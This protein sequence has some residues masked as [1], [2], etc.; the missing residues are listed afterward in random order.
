MWRGF[1]E[2]PF[3]MRVAEARVSEPGLEELL[4]VP[5]YFELLGR[6]MP[7]AGAAALDVL[8]AEHLLVR[9]GQCWDITNLGA[10]LIARDVGAFR[11]I[12]R[13]LV[14]VVQYRG[15]SK[16]STI[17]ETEFR[18]G[19]ATGFET[20]V[21][22]VN[23]L[24]PANEVIQQ[25]LRKSVPMYPGLAIRELVANALIHQD[26]DRTGSGPMLELF[27]DRVEISNPGDPL[28]A[29]ER[30]VDM[31]PRSRNEAL[32]SLLR[33]VGVCEERGSG[34]DKVVAEVERHQLPAPL[35]EN[36]AG[37]TRVV[38]FAHKELKDMDS[39]ERIRACYLHACLQ[40]VMRQP[41]SNSTLRARFGVEKRNSSQVS[42]ILKESVE[43]G[44]IVLVDPD[45]APKLKRYV[46]SWSVGEGPGRRSGS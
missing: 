23:D 21:R 8:E 40:Y 10:L 26:F 5:A 22:F 3:E 20:L 42:R 2:T 38:L 39:S 14:R 17:R 25:A 7:S 32:A 4:D 35:I 27:D 33:R 30:F 36:P 31:P 45:A 1:D 41:M 34:F 15:P 12:A 28:V 46:P 37:S 29:T 6:P 16:L 43:A 44:F 18:S 24:L 11:T 13:K 19:Y 9:S